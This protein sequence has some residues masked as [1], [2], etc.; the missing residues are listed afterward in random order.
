M[1]GFDARFRCAA[2]GVTVMCAPTCLLL[3]RDSE[4]VL[5]KRKMNVFIFESLGSRAG[6][7]SLGLCEAADSRKYIKNR[8]AGDN[9]Y[10]WYGYNRISRE[11]CRKGKKMVRFH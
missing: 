4:P 3:R 8:A 11:K 1:R 7:R 6:D 2:W 5:D 10:A 9:R